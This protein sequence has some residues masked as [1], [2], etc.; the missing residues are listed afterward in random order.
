MSIGAVNGFGFDPDVLT[1]R[2][3]T[4][5]ANRGITSRAQFLTVWAGATQAQQVNFLARMLFGAVRF[6][7][8]VSLTAA[9]LAALGV[10]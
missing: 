10:P 3:A 2:F 7:E 4:E 6:P 1:I 8:D 5:C 9:Q